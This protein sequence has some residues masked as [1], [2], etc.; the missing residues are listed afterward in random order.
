MD[1]ISASQPLFRRVEATLR[2]RIERGHWGEG[3]QIPSENE[4]LVEFGVSRMTVHKAVA[5]LANAGLL[6]RVQGV[7][8][9][10]AEALPGMELVQ[11]GEI[12]T[13]IAARGRRHSARVV[14][15]ERAYPPRPMARRF[16]IA[17]GVALFHS[18]VVHSEDNAPL[19]FE[20]RWVDPSSAPDYLLQ[21]FATSTTTRYL[22]Q[23]HPQPTVEH[24]VEAVL[25]DTGIASALDIKASDACLRLVRRTWVEGRVVTIATLTHP[26]SRFRLGTR[27]Q[28]MARPPPSVAAI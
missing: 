16:A 12:A 17:D 23:R 21:D 3:E 22:L 20:D 28:A 10:V 8:T 26:G 1:R 15:L 18:I 6:R 25:P 4:L 14:L 7:G 27:F 2:D 11:I 13:E 24:I 19:Q 9:F 5:N